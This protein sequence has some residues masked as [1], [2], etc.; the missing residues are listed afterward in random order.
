MQYKGVELNKDVIGK[1]I[2][3]TYSNTRYFTVGQKYEVLNVEKN[4]ISF[5]DNEQDPDN[6]YE[7]WIDVICVI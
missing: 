1:E 6:P 5:S 3:V 7:E 4:W 2:E